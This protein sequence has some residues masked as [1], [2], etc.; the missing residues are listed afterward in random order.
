METAKGHIANTARIIVRLEKE[1]GNLIAF[2]PDSSARVGFIEYSGTVASS[3][4]K[5]FSST[6]YCH[7]EASMDF[8][9]QATI[10]ADQKTAE[11]FVVKYTNYVRTLPEF[12][13]QTYHLRS[14]IHRGK[15]FSVKEVA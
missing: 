13:F 1:T 7:G 10:P 8:Y 14:R 2:F 15:T 6:T 3:S 5:T 9:R 12:E 4:A 11:V